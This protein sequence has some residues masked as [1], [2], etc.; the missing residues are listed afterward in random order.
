MLLTVHPNEGVVA[1][2]RQRVEAGWGTG[3]HSHTLARVESL[4]ISLLDGT[5]DPEIAIGEIGRRCA[6]DGHEL[7]DVAGW[8]TILMSLVPRKIRHRL[9]GRPCAEALANG[10]A[11]ATLDLRP[12][13]RRLAPVAVLHMRLREL[14]DQC[15]HLG[16]DLVRHYVLVV[17]DADTGP[18]GPGARAAVLRQVAEAAQRTFHAGETIAET[19][20]GRI[21]VLGPRRLDLPEVVQALL[22]EVQDRP[23]VGEHRARGWIEPL[24]R[25]SLHHDALIDELARH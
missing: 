9:E 6:I 1:E 5:C 23:Q 13:F 21:I 7:V 14:V 20:S 10:W 24:S 8:L 18:L 25:G 15:N 4:V 17:L 12:A 16:I 11:H 3:T 22:A 19:H 2:W